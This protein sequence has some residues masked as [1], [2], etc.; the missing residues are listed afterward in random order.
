[1]FLRLIVFG[2]SILNY[3]FFN[4]QLIWHVEVVEQVAVRQADV[5]ARAVAPVEVATG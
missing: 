3:S 5:K 2:K 1:L 4:Y